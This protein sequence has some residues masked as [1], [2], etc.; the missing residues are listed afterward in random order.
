[1]NPEANKE[2]L[3]NQRIAKAICRNKKIKQSEEKRLAESSVPASTNTF[4]FSNISIKARSIRKVASALPRSPSKKWKSLK[5]DE[6]IQTQYQARPKQEKKVR[7][8]RKVNFRKM[9]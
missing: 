3:G 6:K 1:M 4:N 5:F 9:N 2:R 7:G 8:G